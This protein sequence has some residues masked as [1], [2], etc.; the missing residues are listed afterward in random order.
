MRTVRTVQ[1]LTS[2]RLQKLWYKSVV[3]FEIYGIVP[4]SGY[5]RYQERMSPAKQGEGASN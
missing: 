1:R 2:S 3:P 4:P 5:G